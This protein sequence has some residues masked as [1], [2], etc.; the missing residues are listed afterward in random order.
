MSTSHAQQMTIIFVVPFIFFPTDSVPLFHSVY[1]YPFLCCFALFIMPCH[2]KAFGRIYLFIHENRTKR[3]Y[4][5]ISLCIYVSV[6]S[7]F[8]FCALTIVYAIASVFIER[9][10]CARFL[11]LLPIFHTVV[12]SICVHTHFICRLFQSQILSSILWIGKRKLGLFP[13]ECHWCGIPS[14]VSFSLNLFSC[15]H[16]F[17]RL[18][19]SYF[20][21][22]WKMRV[23]ALLL[24]FS[25]YSFIFFFH[26]AWI[27]RIFFVLNS[28]QYTLFIHGNNFLVKCTYSIF[29]FLRNSSNV[30]SLLFTSLPFNHHIFMFPMEKHC[31]MHILNE[32]KAFSKQTKQTAWN[33]VNRKK[34]QKVCRILNVCVWLLQYEKW[35]A[36][37]NL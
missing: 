15:K 37:S 21:Y 1:S 33:R 22:D 27:K 12:E 2:A 18:F 17:D 9:S 36:I 26:H 4:T 32:W 30:C 25:F 16:T 35:S 13:Q 11:T 31:T 28:F 24:F 34:R 7:I 14:F 8:F 19:L 6:Q 3:K 5:N 23:L 29:Y 20:K 10:T